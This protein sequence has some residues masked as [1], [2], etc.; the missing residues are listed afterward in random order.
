MGLLIDGIWHDQWYDTKTTGGKFVRKDSAFRNWVTSDGSAGPTGK[1]GFKAEKGRYHLYVS[2]ACPWAHRTIIFRA[3]KGLEEVISISVVDHLMKSKGWEFSTNPGTIPDP[4][5]GAKTLS[6]IYVKANP[7]YTGRVTVPV[8]WDTQ[9]NTIVSN[10]SSE[11]LRMFNSA[12]SAFAKNDIDFCP[13][14]LRDDIDA[15]NEI[16]YHT[17]NNGVY[18]AGFAT[19]QPA[20]EEA[21]SAL[22]ESL[23]KMEAILSET[24]YLVGDQLTEADWRFFTTLLRFDAVYVGHF[25]CNIRRIA[26]YPNL[27]NY[28]RALYQ[29]PGIAQTVNM[30]HIKRHY[31]ESHDTINP[32][33]VVPTGPEQDLTLPHNRP[34]I[35]HNSR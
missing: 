1:G 35:A 16:V 14:A 9:E 5:F 12:F 8:L 25:K 21:V 30:D 7:T 10:E 23:D 33:A 26:D 28:L 11:I 15:I 6:E 31:Y 27:F 3:L 24:P 20:Y 29:V 13:E 4:I 2:H 22:F 32:T 19:T 17:I 34:K 18:K